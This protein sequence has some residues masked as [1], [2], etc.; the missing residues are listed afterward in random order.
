MSAVF[1]SPLFGYLGQLWSDVN[2]YPSVFGSAKPKIAGESKYLNAP[3]AGISFALTKK[4]KV[5]SIFLYA[6]GIEN[7]SQ[8]DDALPGGL[9]F[10]QS[11]KHVRKAL[12][13]PVFS[14][15][16]GGIGLMAIDFSF[17]RYESETHYLRVTYAEN[18]VTI[19]LIT[20]GMT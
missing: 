10:A 7:F 8:Y 1:D 13:D 12:G 20:L 19:R 18:D 2:I 6:K 5:E 3:D 9:S 4:L 16:V 11:R 15:E 17:D 14:G